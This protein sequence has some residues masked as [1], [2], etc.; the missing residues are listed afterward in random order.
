VQRRG[1][2]LMERDAETLVLYDYDYVSMASL[3]LINE[4]FPQTHIATC[5]SAGSTS[6]YIVIFSYSNRRPLLTSYAF[7]H[8]ALVCLSI[9]MSTYLFGYERL[10]G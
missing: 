3:S 10:T 9:C 5:Q 2:R 1:G 4:Q 8:V 6:G 7:I